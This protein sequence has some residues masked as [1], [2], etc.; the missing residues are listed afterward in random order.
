MAP[1]LWKYNKSIK[2]NK[3]QIV[4]FRKIGYHTTAVIKLCCIDPWIVKHV[5]YILWIL[6]ISSFILGPVLTHSWWRHQMETFSALLALCAGNS[7]A[8]VN[9]PHKGQWRGAL[10]FPLICVWING[11]VNNSEA[12]DLKCYQAHYDITVMES[13]TKCPSYR[14]RRPSGRSDHFEVTDK[15]THWFLMAAILQDRT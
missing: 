11:W 5:T 13:E 3:E 10:M 12:G 8:P 9:S 1:H 15:L 14:R 6:I 4:T 2:H 7:P